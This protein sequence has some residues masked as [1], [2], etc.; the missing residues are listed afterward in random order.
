MFTKV[1][2]SVCSIGLS[3]KLSVL[4]CHCLEKWEPELKYLIKG[5]E[6]KNNE[7]DFQR[8]KHSLDH[9]LPE[10]KNDISNHNWPI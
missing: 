10:G 6:E 1:C 7:S 2:I 8:E 4:Q 5:Q 9:L 3:K